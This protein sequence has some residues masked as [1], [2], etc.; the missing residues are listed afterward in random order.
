M[1]RFDDLHLFIRTAALGS[2][3]AAAREVSLAPGQ[4][5]AAIGR[6]E[7]ELD[8]RLFARSTRSLRLT[9]AGAR[10]L[11]YAVESLERLHEGREQLGDTQQTLRGNLSIAMPSDL[12]RHVLLPW[13][14]AF[15]QAHPAVRLRLLV[16][17]GLIDIFRDPVDIAIRY[18]PPAS[19][20]YVALPLVEDNRRVVVAAPDYLA[21]CGRPDTVEALANHR[22]V[23]FALGGQTYDRW[24][25]PR[26]DAR[27]Q[28]AVQ[29]SLLCDDGDIARRWAIDGH[30]IAYKSWL[31]VSHDVG[32][33]RLQILLPHEPCEPTPLM[34]VSAHRRQVSPAVRALYEVL[35]EGL[36]Q[37]AAQRAIHEAAARQ[38]WPSV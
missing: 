9:E 30:G 28:V 10:Y 37:I 19:G 5:S 11:P 4:V 21:R 6:L 2:F 23:V 20:S 32:A 17:D 33:G 1:I 8:T 13:L 24:S 14:T 35:R 34:M 38:A 15:G 25:F 26:A 12:G 29:A 3:S 16:S 7:R 18:G 31:D 27:Q 36:G 22:C